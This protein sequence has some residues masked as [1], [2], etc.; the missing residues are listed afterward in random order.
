MQAL[1]FSLENV[2]IEELKS[3]EYEPKLLPNVGKLL[4]SVCHSYRLFIIDRPNVLIKGSVDSNRFLE[5]HTKVCSQIAKFGAS[6]H[7]Y[8]YCQHPDWGKCNCAFP[9]PYMLENILAEHDIK[10]YDSWYITQNPEGILS[11]Y[12]SGIRSI[13]INGATT[14]ISTLSPM[15]QARDLSEAMNQIK[16]IQM[17]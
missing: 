6:I 3:P 15:F 5:I 4:H 14:E 7:G 16:V 11:A 8:R 12:F 13:L 1:I 10:T 2:L 17:S 9:N